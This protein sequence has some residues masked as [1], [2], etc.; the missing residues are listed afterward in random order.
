MLGRGFENRIE[1]NYFKFKND[2]YSREFHETWLE[3]YNKDLSLNSYLWIDEKRLMNFLQITKSSKRI[4]E[5]N[6]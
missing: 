6:F 1:K 4:Q 3:E 5:I 2:D